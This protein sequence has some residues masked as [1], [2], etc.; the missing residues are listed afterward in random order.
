MLPITDLPEWM[1]TNDNFDWIEDCFSSDIKKSQLFEPSLTIPSSC[2]ETQSSL[3]FGDDLLI[4]NH[5]PE[6][7]CKV[8]VPQS[9]VLSDLYEPT[10]ISQHGIYQPFETSQLG[11]FQ[12]IETFE[13]DTSYQP[14]E[15]SEVDTYQ[16]IETS[17]VDIYQPID[18]S[19]HDTYQST[20]VH[21]NA[22]VYSSDCLNTGEEYPE[23]VEESKVEVIEL[24][25]DVSFQDNC[26]SCP[27]SSAGMGSSSFIIPNENNFEC[28][29]EIVATESPV[30]P[31]VISVPLTDA[32]PLVQNP[33]IKT[34]RVSNIQYCN[35]PLRTIM[36][37][38]PST[39]SS[40]RQQKP[41]K[42]IINLKRITRPV[43]REV[44]A[45]PSVPTLKD[46]IS[47]G[48]GDDLIREL[49]SPVTENQE[50]D[51]SI[52]AT[53]DD[54][55][56]DYESNFADS[57]CSLFS[58]VSYVSGELQMQPE[59]PKDCEFS[60]DLSDYEY[61]TSNSSRRAPYSLAERKLRKKDQNKR[62]A[63]R[64]RQKKKD[65]EDTV[66][67]SL[68]KE[69]LKHLEL[70]GKYN[71]LHMEVQLMKKLMREVI[72]AKRK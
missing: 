25:N 27:V 61:S 13:V 32:V 33:V 12:P 72:A 5:V 22:E 68:E 48:E 41:K 55:L 59:S 62:A 70:K 45:E 65:V 58:P 4:E 51:T 53:E 69:E 6:K 38:N 57:Q 44:V 2:F 71:A 54:Q 10:E 26:I 28:I 52:I 35:S 46:I 29:E 1:E 14:I 66:L 36:K 67:T 3:S 34:I 50:S 60:E 17:E 31:L 9:F 43:K 37:A 19:E 24:P 11:V 7:V 63:L 18:V 42:I 40:K 30:S 49:V 56:T 64:Y 8:E 39:I 21:N 20:S 15:N 16:P 23:E 47:S